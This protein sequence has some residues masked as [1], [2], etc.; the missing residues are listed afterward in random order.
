MNLLH[1]S[2]RLR[3][4]IPADKP[5]RNNTCAIAVAALIIVCFVG[6]LA[7][8]VPRGILSNTDEV[9]T[10]E[11]SREMLLTSPWVVHFNFERSFAKPPLQYWLT[12]LTL[13]RFENRTL[14]VRIWPLVYGVLTAVT[15]GCLV[16]VIA[17][18]R[19]WVM[20]LSLVILVTSKLFSAEASRA[21][22]DTG[23]AFFTTIAI[24]CAQL[25]R[26]NPQ[27]WLGVAVACWLG[28]LQKIPLIFLVWLL[29][30]IVRGSSPVERRTLFSGWL[31]GSIV[32][33]VVASAIWPMLQLA[34]YGM[35]VTSVFNE[36][37]VVWLGPEHLGARPY[38]EIPFRLTTTAWIGGGLF[39]LAAAFVVLLWKKQRFSTATR[40]I[41]I[42]CIGLI[43]LAVLFNFRS[44]RYMVPI[45]PSLCLLLAVVFHRFL[46]QS[47][48]ARIAAAVLLALM[49]IASLTQAA[50]EIHL[51]QRNTSVHIVNGQIQLRDE[52]TSVLN[53]K[54]IA[55]ELGSLQQPGAKI[56]LVKAIKTGNDLLYDSFYLFHGNLRFPVTKLTVD[57]L[58]AAPQTAPVL[59][60]C[61]ARDFPVVQEAYPHVQTQFTR[62]QFVLW[63][64]DAP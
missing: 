36:E 64:V 40:E 42:V 47:S 53:E 28:S 4:R 31:V 34:K 25:A 32:F 16:R 18:D 63:R 14:A 54:R 15:L 1:S 11:R 30:L 10:A 44:V 62:A 59:G 48:P 56:V 55:E 43:A 21:L 8:E 22:L 52:Q 41:A 57:A 13:P 6:W 37:V 19:P 12:S 38:L 3:I 26:R 20:P 35:P 7:F 23:L 60:V 58:R 27:W 50:T 51:R 24:L 2:D 49:L 33:A 39:A 17:P 5:S 46:E 29:I 9:L 45:V 61:V